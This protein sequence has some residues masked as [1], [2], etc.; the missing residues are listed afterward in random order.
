MTLLTTDQFVVERSGVPDPG[1]TTYEVKAYNSSMSSNFGAF[2]ANQ[3][4]DTTGPFS[5]AKITL[6]INQ[7]ID[8]NTFVFPST[9]WMYDF[10]VPGCV[11]GYD[12]S[13]DKK[14][15]LIQISDDGV[16][17]EDFGTFDNNLVNIHIPKRYAKLW[18]LESAD[19]RNCICTSGPV[20]VSLYSLQTQNLMANLEDTD[21][22]VVCRSGTPYKATGAE[23]KDSLGSGGIFPS[24]NDITISPSVPGTGTQADPFILATRIAAPAGSTVVTSE[25]ITFTDQPPSTNVV[26][27]DNSTGVGTRFSQPVTQTDANGDWSGQLQYADSPDSTADIDYVGDLQIGLLHFRWQVDQKLNDRIPTDV[28]SVNLVDT[29]SETG[30]RFTD[31]T[32][33]FTSVVTDGF[34]LPTKT[35]EAHVD[36]SLRIT[37][38][39]SEIVGANP[40]GPASGTEYQGGTQTNTN[41]SVNGSWDNIFA[42]PTL[43][44]NVNVTVIGQG[45][46]AVYNLPT[47]LTANS[48]VELVVG[49]GPGQSDT[50]AY[51]VLDKPTPNQIYFPFGT[52]STYHPIEQ[53]VPAGETWEI[54]KIQFF[55][56]GTAA[57]GNDFGTIVSITV[58]GKPF[59]IPSTVLTLADNKDLSVFQPGDLVQQNE[60]V[61]ALAPV[62]STTIYDG[63]GEANTQSLTTGINLLN[64]GGLTWIKPRINVDQ[65]QANRNSH[66][67][68][69]NV[70]GDN[71]LSSND[72]QALNDFQGLNFTDTGYVVPANPR[73]NWG[74]V[75]YVSWNFRA[76]PKFFDVQTYVGG[77]SGSSTTTV[78]HDLDS[79]PG[80][81]I[82]KSTNGNGDWS[83][84]N[85]NLNGG[86]NP[87]DSY[88]T[89]NRTDGESQA[90]ANWGGT[91]PTSTEFT[92]SGNANGG[93]E[94]VAYLFAD[95]PGLIKCGSYTGALDKQ[96][97]C[98]FTPQWVMIKR[99]TGSGDWSILDQYRYRDPAGGRYN[100]VLMAQADYPENPNLSGDRWILPNAD[101][102]QLSSISWLDTNDSNST[103]IFIAIAKD[104]MADLTTTPAGL[105]QSTTGNTMTLT[106][107]TDGWSANTGNTATGPEQIVEN[108]R[109]YLKFDS[110]GAVSDLQTIPQDPPYTTTTTNPSLNLTFPSTFPSGETPDDELPDG[111]TL[112]VGIASE[113]LTN[114]SPVSGY[115]EAI[116]QPKPEPSVS[117][118]FSTTLYPY[119]DPKVEVTNG[120]NLLDNG[121]LIWLKGRLDTGNI[122]HCLFDTS[123]GSN[124]RLT[125]NSTEPESSGN[126]IVWKDNG[127]D[128]SGIGNASN[129]DGTKDYVSWSFRKAPKFFDIQTYVGDK[130]AGKKISHAL[131]SVPGAMIVKDSDN[132]SAWRV[133]H[134]DLGAT[135]SLFLNSDQKEYISNS[136]WNDTA[137]TSIEFTV[138]NDDDTNKAGG[139]FV[140]YLF[141]DEPGL[142]KCGSSTGAG[143]VD[144]GFEPQWLMVK[145]TSEAGPWI[146]IDNKRPGSTPSTVSKFLKP[147]ATDAE[148]EIAVVLNSTGFNNNALSSTYIYVAIAAPVVDTMTAEQFVESQVKFLTYDNRK[149][150]KAGEDAIAK[151][152]EVVAQAENLGIDVSQVKKALGK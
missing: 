22:M 89:L 122:K 93:Q 97:D 120:I 4:W 54:T 23:I 142:I 119:T 77:E 31:Q 27:T 53:A 60:G 40:N 100:A 91:P 125:T 137:P 26:W 70:L 50:Y 94:F 146:V 117:D 18:P 101:G 147:N 3:I 63:N 112:S 9:Y 66:V 34:P 81:I 24:E 29:G 111:T 98:G 84:Y 14:N 150:V 69:T 43:N 105:F 103:Y 35:I 123:R 95:E 132:G 96:I 59:G 115:E 143:Q 72:T 46:E 71:F 68:V 110:N 74:G 38:E 86:I 55:A 133:Y 75:A 109:L 12:E 57:S 80:M 151:R 16:T 58:D 51:L 11:L 139:E 44:P 42:N 17:Y 13:Y 130:I 45:G 148:A 114:R 65:G 64:G 113:N 136:S 135:K 25:T 144:V 106:P 131:T 15:G 129:Y 134:K 73:I 30:P 107:Q 47:I 87:E 36:G 127:F 32:F 41:I 19:S 49:A 33:A 99:I 20:S 82:C 2:F 62:F 128:I 67:L 37:P 121:G 124:M 126:T 85:K 145:A 116:V 78:Q 92:V 88:L 104:A 8:T 39:T 1:V 10:G 52:G 28:V 7:P 141:A 56:G 76:A 6:Q 108:A 118:W 138:G 61:T 83:V 5:P 90:V 79:I 48:K 140:A 102:F 152:D 21:L 149:E